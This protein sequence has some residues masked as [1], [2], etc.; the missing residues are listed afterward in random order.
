MSDAGYPGQRDAFA[1][2]N[3]FAALANLIR[4]MAAGDA[5]VAL[6]LVQAVTPNS[7]TG[8]PPL[9]N[10]QPMV[11]Q[12]DQKGNATPHGI[13]NNIPTMRIQA[14]KSAFICNPK[15][16]DIG[17]VICADRDISSAIANQAPSNPGS[18]R[19]FDWSNGMYVGGFGSVDPTTYVE[20][21]DDTGVTIQV[22]AGNPLTINADTINI[23]ASD[24]SSNAA[25]NLTGTLTTSV[26]VV[27][28]SVS[29]HSHVHSGVTTGSGDTGP[30]T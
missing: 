14:G 19:R 2:T 27:A 30:P 18:F 1:G 5:H 12:V 17:A 22:A 29:G 13:V 10:V 28:D 21:D 26:D 4:Q 24:G 20:V 11:A 8:A 6:V 15:V 7:V 25:V 23:A 3:V 9:V 16:G